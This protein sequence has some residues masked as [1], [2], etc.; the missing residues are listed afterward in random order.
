MKKKRIQNKNWRKVKLGDVARFYYGKMPNRE[1]LNI[2]GIYPVYT[3][4]QNV[5]YYNEYNSDGDL[6][7]V[8]RGVG[9]TGDI[10]ISPAKSFV[11]NL[12]IVIKLDQ[13]LVDKNYLFYKFN[14][15]LRYL[16]SGSAQSQITISDLEKINI[17]L[18]SLIVQQKLAK[19]LSGF[20]DK[21]EL[22]NKINQNL[23]QTA[24]AILNDTGLFNKF[25]ADKLGD[26]MVQRKE[27]FKKYE[28]WKDLKL[29]DLG[30]F[31]QKSLAIT[32]YGIGGEIKTSGVRFKKWDILFGAVRPYFHKV[33]IAPFDGVTNSSVFVICPK[34]ESHGSLLITTLFSEN[35]INY[36]SMSASGTK[37]PV[38]KW[39]D[40]CNMK[41]SIPGEK[42]IDNFNN[43]IRPFYNIIIKNVEENEKL[44]SLR[45]LLL[46]KLMSGEIKV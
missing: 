26:L 37:M 6:I 22:N 16:D 4:Y 36:A 41:L 19:I 13:K 45:D 38:I 35:V 31:P 44:A 27:K 24:Q 2:G 40:L 8:A 18:P 9:G 29:L 39:E 17:E 12:S 23:E 10:K 3:G 20:D 34:E 28:D 30:R 11:T 1:R 21:I 15:G 5:G 33:V 32:S 14:R 43:V 46:P 25:G 7:V 42:I